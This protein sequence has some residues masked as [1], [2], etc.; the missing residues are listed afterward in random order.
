MRA[1]DVLPAPAKINLALHVT[2]RRPD[3]Y[4]L[5]DSLVVFTEV[6]DRVFLSPAEDISLEV[7]GPRAD[8]VPA[9]DN[10]LLR[11]ARLL[12]EKFQVSGGVHIHLEKNIP[13]AAGLGGGSAD[14]AA[15]LRGLVP[16]WSL[17]VLPD[18]LAE[19]V[20]ALGADVPVCLRLKPARMRGIGEDITAV[21]GVPSL[22]AILVNPGVPVSTPAVFRRR[23]GAF[24]EGLPSLPH[25]WEEETFLAWLKAAR[26]DLEVP[27]VEEAP[28]IGKVLQALQGSAGCRL[29]RMSGSGATCF[30]LFDSKPGAGAAAEVLR[31]GHSDWWCAVTPLLS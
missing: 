1:P 21:S 13:V 16:L 10:S 9:E 29:A 11:A 24:S 5:L 22:W 17:S 3:G 25:H 18:Q 20:L 23:R 31:R 8:E 4:H 2:G 14:A 26:N 7:S 12:S 30:G 15:V 6:A 27:A 28:V 19:V